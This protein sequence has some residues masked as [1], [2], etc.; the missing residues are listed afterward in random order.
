M[1]GFILI[2]FIGKYFYELAIKYN[3][4]KW[5]FAIL[6]VVTYYVG[7]A[8]GGLVVGILDDLFNFGLDFDNRLILSLIAL[9]FGAAA[10]YLFYYLLEKSWS[11]RAK[12]EEVSIEDIGKTEDELS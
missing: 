1:I 5:L 4:K 8:I 10:C 12:K 9:P 11:K 3:E 6:G 7:S 2:Y